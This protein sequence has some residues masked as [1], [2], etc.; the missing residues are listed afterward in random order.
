MTTCNYERIVAEETPQAKQL[1][2]YL[3]HAG[4][5]SVIDVGCGP[6]N[7]V[8]AINDAGIQAVGVDIDDRCL[9]TPGCTVCDITASA[10]P[11]A[12]QAVL[13]LEVGEHIPEGQA[14]DY[15][16][17]IAGCRPELLI[18]SAA[19]PGQGGD[20]HINCQPKH[21]WSKLLE[22]AGYEWDL[23]ATEEF[24]LFMKAGPHMGWLVNNVMLWRP[25]RKP[26]LHLIGLFHTI[27][28]AGHSHCAFT[29]K[30]LRFPRMM[31]DQG[32]RVVEYSNGES[33]SACREKVR[34]LEEYQL[35]QM[36]GTR[37]AA[38]FHGDIATM[39]S[40]HHKRFENKLR[41]ELT[42]RV[43]AGD[44]ICHPFG[45]AH[46]S[47]LGRFP[48]CRHIETGIG[49]PDLMAYPENGG[50]YKVFESQ[51]WRHYHM[52]KE[53]RSG[54]NYEWVIP[55]YFDID[56]WEF[57]PEPGRYI[58]YLGRICSIKGLTTVREI[59]SRTNLPVILCGQGD[60]EPFAGPNM[61]FRSP[62]TGMARS[63]FLGNALC[64]LMPT[65]YV[66]PFGGSGVEA[67]LTGTPLL[68]TSWGAF[69]ET[70]EE[71]VS[72]FRCQ[73]LREWLEAVEACKTLDRKTI[74]DRARRLYSLEACGRQYTR[75][76]NMLHGLGGEGWYS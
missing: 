14:G 8:A 61:E 22:G 30:V 49:Y 53:G 25:A 21:Y 16:R 35:R 64:A 68:A 27:C 11:P 76:F 59:A 7:Y 3:L 31:Q 24:V 45:R 44:I 17:Y 34:I 72:G 58:A 42:V 50:A 73:T 33:Q 40:T 4:I 54:H 60:T 15:I 67:Q 36:I 13:S 29:G 41:K 20:G 26:T 48:E 19:Q 52:G 5:S 23:E 62:I 65:D 71:G 57:Q 6:G 75:A 69:T 39:G 70:I 9:G 46:E 66:E 32:W 37:Q 28:D 38:D 51:A 56:E 10:P 2:Q 12:Y 18:F 63:E 43:E 47:L 1:A 74:S 55:N